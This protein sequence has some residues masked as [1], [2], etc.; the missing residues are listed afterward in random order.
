MQSVFTDTM[1][2]DNLF[3]LMMHSDINTV[4]SICLAKSIPYCHDAY[5]WKKKFD[6]DHLPILTQVLPMTLNEWR[7]EY[8]RVET[9]ADMALDIL[10]HLQNNKA[11]VL[12]DQSSEEFNFKAILPFALRSAMRNYTPA[13]QTFDV[14]KI[15][16]HRDNKYWVSSVGVK[17]NS[18]TIDF[19]DLYDVLTIIFY[20]YPDIIYQFS[21]IQEWKI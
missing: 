15:R 1:N 8:I 11:E 4:R 20:H 9:A 3:H 17:T 12:M 2:Q 18:F 5:F 16:Y 7:R 14:L 21:Q 13:H 19:D 6:H 10:E